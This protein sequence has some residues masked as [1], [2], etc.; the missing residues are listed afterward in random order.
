MHGQPDNVD[1]SRR[2]ASRAKQGAVIGREQ[3]KAEWKLYQAGMVLTSADAV[4]QCRLHRGANQKQ[5]LDQ[6]D[7]KPAVGEGAGVTRTH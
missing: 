5:S 2:C 4:R 3:H 1:R 6:A 7:R